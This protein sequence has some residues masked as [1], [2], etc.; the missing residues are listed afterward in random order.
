[1]LHTIII[2]ILLKISHLIQEKF[3]V[4]IQV[5]IFPNIIDVSLET[6]K[7]LTNQQVTLRGI[8]SFQNLQIVS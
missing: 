7:M 3:F 6:R 4:E 2:Y 8:P 1:M 5:F